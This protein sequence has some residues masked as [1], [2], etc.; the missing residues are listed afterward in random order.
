MTV[1]IQ[2]CCCYATICDIIKP[3]LGDTEIPF[4][5]K[6]EEVQAISNALEGVIS[7]N[8]PELH[9]VPNLTVQTSAVSVFN[10]MS[11]DHYG[12]STNQR[13]CTGT[14]HSICA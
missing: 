7:V 12:Q 13:F 11:P 9:K 6:K 5:L 1:K 4:V 8:V 3:V 10:Q 2:S 14:G